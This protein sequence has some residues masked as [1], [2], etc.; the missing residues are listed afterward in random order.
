MATTGGSLIGKADS[1]LVSAAFKEGESNV[2]ADL[3]SVYDKREQAFKTFGEGME[4]LLKNLGADDK[5]EKEKTKEDSE[6]LIN[7]GVEFGNDAIMTINQTVSESYREAMEKAETDLDKAKTKSKFNTYSQKIQQAGATLE[8]MI[9]N[10]ANGQLLMNFNSDEQKL[11]AAMQKDLQN[12]TNLTNAQPNEDMTDIVYTLPGTDVKMTMGELQSKMGIKDNSV[13]IDVN[14]LIL[15]VTKNT[16][17]ASKEDAIQDFK[18][19]LNNRMNTSN[20]IKVAGT[21][22]FQGMKYSVEDMIL[23]KTEDIRNNEFTLELFETLKTLDV[24]NDGVIGDKD[25]ATFATPANAAALMKEIQSNDSLYKEVIANAVSNISGEK[26]YGIMLKNNQEKY[27]VPGTTEWERVRKLKNENKETSKFGL[28]LDTRMYTLG[29]DQNHGRVFGRDVENNIETFKA[30]Q[31]KGSG[32]FQG[33]DGSNW[34]LKDGKWFGYNSETGDFTKPASF[35]TIAG[36]L[37]WSNN[38]KIMEYLRIQKKSNQ[39][40]PYSIEFLNK[41]KIEK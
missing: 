31:S 24:N 13:G 5:K 17:V 27:L 22:V 39:T 3:K 41:F 2:P 6:V 25:D 23:G 18:T 12:N 28:D 7:A 19:N 34:M 20:D 9:Q 11:F 8:N 30:V 36:Q 40:I 15:D 21:T 10:S 26:S 37:K 14:K 1:T 16:N 32:P 35:N 29:K 38:P 33:W 4:K